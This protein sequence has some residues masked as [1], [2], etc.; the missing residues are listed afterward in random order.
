MSTFENRVMKEDASKS[1]TT[2][3]NTDTV[4]IDPDN[5]LPTYTRSNFQALLQ[6]YDT[7]YD[8]NIVGYNGAVGLFE[9][10]VN[11]GPLQPPQRKGR[12]LQYARSKLVELQQRFDDLERHG[13]FGD[14]NISTHHFS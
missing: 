4:K 14:Q 11:M 9:A 7:V 13:I 6:Q 1:L 12:C 8:S 5:I 3:Y 2:A 10:I